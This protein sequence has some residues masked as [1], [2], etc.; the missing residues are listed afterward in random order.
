MLII[1][2]RFR[3]K[4]YLSLKIGSLVLTDLDQ[5][6]CLEAGRVLDGTLPLS[7]YTPIDLS[8]GNPELEGV[9]LEDP[10]TCQG[11][12]DLVLER[13]GARVAFGGYL[14]HRNLYRGNTS[15]Q[16]GE[17]ARD[18][19]LGV[20]FWT[21]AGTRVTAPLE[22]RVHSFKNNAAKGDY[23]PTIILEHRYQG[24]VFYTLYGHLSVESLIGLYPGKQIEKGEVLGT[25]GTPDI[26][27]NYAPHLHFQLILDLQ[28]KEGDY[29]G[30]CRKSELGFYQANCPDPNILFS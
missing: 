4:A 21:D 28:G 6:A 7:A 8:T 30:V 22:G 5:F 2:L 3:F 20:D 16:A 24:L 25:L 23:G 10:Y 14:E 17:E 15:F 11:Y 12:V 19:H 29:P 18:I 26:N 1:L 13:A 27:V 9:D